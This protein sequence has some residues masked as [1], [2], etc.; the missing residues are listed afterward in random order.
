L[1]SP[2]GG[3]GRPGSRILQ[4][5]HSDCGLI[6]RSG[7]IHACFVTARLGSM[8]D[9]P[10]KGKS[11]HSGSFL[12]KRTKKLLHVGPRSI[13]KDRSRNDQSFL[14]LFFKKEGLT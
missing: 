8:G 10:C 7:R 4:S 11:K 6:L 3:I 14:L 13:Q 5:L 2:G 9:V 12:K 1:R